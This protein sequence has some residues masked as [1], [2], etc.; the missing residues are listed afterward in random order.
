MLSFNA[1]SSNIDEVLSINLS[2]NVFVFGVFNNIHH[3]DWLTCS[4]GTDRLGELYL[5]FSAACPAAI[6]HRNLFFHL[7]QQIKS[8]ESKVK[9]RQASNPSNPAKLAYAIKTKTLIMERL[10]NCQ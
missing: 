7:F 5:K 9:F 10:T 8:S 2:A 3:E 4:G 6:V 1:I